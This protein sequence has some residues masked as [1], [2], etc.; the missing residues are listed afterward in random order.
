MKQ[1]FRRAYPSTECA[2]LLHPHDLTETRAEVSIARP[3]RRAFEETELLSQGNDDLGL[4]KERERKINIAQ[5]ARHGTALPIHEVGDG[6]KRAG[7]GKAGELGAKSV[8]KRHR[9]LA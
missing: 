2:Q 4:L 7:S 8:A 9:H 5:N 1:G 6:T 3:A